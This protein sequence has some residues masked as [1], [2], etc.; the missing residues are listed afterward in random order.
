MR[1]VYNHEVGALSVNGLQ[2]AVTSSKLFISHHEGCITDTAG[3]GA[4]VHRA[5]SR[6]AAGMADGLAPWPELLQ[7]DGTESGA[8]SSE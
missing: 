5:A 3:A 2:Q 7:Q 4:K 8:E 1:V 6:E